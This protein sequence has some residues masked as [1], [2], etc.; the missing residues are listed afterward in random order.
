MPNHPVK[1]W[2]YT[3]TCLTHAYADPVGKMK[4][5]HHVQ[6]IE[7]NRHFKQKNRKNRNFFEKQRSSEKTEKN[8]QLDS[9]L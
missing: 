3:Y 6:K 4:I 2:W 8:R 9:L 1:V 7:K 5:I